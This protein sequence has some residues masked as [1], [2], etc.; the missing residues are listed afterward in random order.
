ML[1]TRILFSANSV[2]DGLDFIPNRYIFKQKEKKIYYIVIANAHIERNGWR[3]T[4]MALYTPN[5]VI[6]NRTKMESVC[7]VFD[8]WQTLFVKWLILPE[9][10]L[11]LFLSPFDFRH[12]HTH[13]HTCSF[14]VCQMKCAFIA[15]T[16]T[17]NWNAFKIVSKEMQIRKWK[18]E[19]KRILNL[20]THTTESVL[21]ITSQAKTHCERRRIT[22]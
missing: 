12:T 4:A 3:L 19:R 6:E 14:F 1:L 20:K 15:F 18:K 16:F 8:A 7:Y 11:S 5:L 13:T 9:R 10:T 2:F 22:K 17:P 21:C